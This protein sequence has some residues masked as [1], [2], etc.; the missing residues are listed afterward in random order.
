MIL[1]VSCDLWLFIECSFNTGEIQTVMPKLVAVAIEFG[2]TYSGYA[3]SFLHDYRKDPLRVISRNWST[4]DHSFSFKTKTCVLFSENKEFHSF[5]FRAEDKYVNLKMDRRHKD[6]Y[7]FRHFLT[8]LL[9]KMVKKYLFLI[10][11]K[12][13]TLKAYY[14]DAW[15]NFLP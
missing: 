1:L 9:T 2:S 14:C 4:G 5:G 7:F 8:N 12:C 3:Y 13:L 15:C 11:G 6:W 10:Q